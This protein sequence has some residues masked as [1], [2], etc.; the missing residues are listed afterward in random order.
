MDEYWTAYQVTLAGGG[1]ISLAEPGE[2]GSE[3]PGV[4]GAT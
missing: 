1:S 4:E 2:Q 3:M